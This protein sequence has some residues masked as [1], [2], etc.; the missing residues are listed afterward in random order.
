MYSV[1]VIVAVSIS[2]Q[3]S[4]SGTPA[5]PRRLASF[6][7]CLGAIRCVCKRGSPCLQGL[8]A[9][10]MTRTK[11][12]GP[13]SLLSYQQYQHH[14]VKCACS[15]FSG[16][17]TTMPS[18]SELHEDHVGLATF[19]NYAF[20]ESHWSC[21]ENPRFFSSNRS[22]FRRLANCGVYPPRKFKTSPIMDLCLS[23]LVVLDGHSNQSHS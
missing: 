18:S 8:W 13:L 4:L 1:A 12:H 21:T 6:L 5:A 11:P 10:D 15:R 22:L 14:P 23:L 3:V 19:Y 2:F 7:L 20:S 17:R 16:W 9:R